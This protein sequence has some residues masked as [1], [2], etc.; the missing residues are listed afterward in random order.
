[1]RQGKSPRTVMD[2]GSTL[3]AAGAIT[4][5]AKAPHSM[6]VVCLDAHEARNHTAIG[7]KDT[8]EAH[9]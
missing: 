2:I 5:R 1:M 3:N 9:E 6:E 4:P 7:M 8:C